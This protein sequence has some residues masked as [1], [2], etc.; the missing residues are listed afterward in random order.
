MISLKRASTC[1]NST[2]GVVNSPTPNQKTGL[3][4]G[5]VASAIGGLTYLVQLVDTASK[6]PETGRKLSGLFGSPVF[7]IILCGV[8]LIAGLV[9]VRRKSTSPSA[10]KLVANRGAPI[11]EPT[12][13]P[14]RKSV[15]RPQLPKLHAGDLA[16]LRDAKGDD[17][18]LVA[19]ALERIEMSLAVEPEALFQSKRSRARKEMTWADGLADNSGESFSMALDECARSHGEGSDPNFRRGFALALWYAG[20]LTARGVQERNLLHVVQAVTRRKLSSSDVARIK[21]W[22]IKLSQFIQEPS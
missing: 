1:W 11:A 21:A 17:V 16:S 8:G 15:F 9:L 7:W 2:R 13:A 3:M 18:A 6:L 5:I 12:K 22:S 10:E 20:D 14:A 19:G 4:F